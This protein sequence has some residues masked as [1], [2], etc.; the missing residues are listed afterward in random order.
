MALA[1]HSRIYLRFA[2]KGIKG[3]NKIH[4]YIRLY[5]CVYVCVRGGNYLSQIRVRVMD[6]LSWALLIGETVV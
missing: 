6:T 1:F 3:K 5:M 4:T 2:Q